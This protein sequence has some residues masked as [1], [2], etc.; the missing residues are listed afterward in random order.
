MA[1]DRPISKRND[2]A[3]TLKLRRGRVYQCAEVC[4]N[5]TR[6]FQRLVIRTK[7]NSGG[8][9][10]QQKLLSDKRNRKGMW[11]VFLFYRKGKG[12]A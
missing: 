4:L 9:G 3:A 7:G 10:V 2:K 8:G 1:Q 5:Q 11:V 6:S 12:R